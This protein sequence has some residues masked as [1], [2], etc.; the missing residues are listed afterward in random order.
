G[1]AS[2]RLAIDTA[3]LS[4][5][6]GS[7]PSALPRAACYD[8]LART[9]RQQPPGTLGAMARLYRY[10]RWDGTQAG[11]ELD[12]E[13]V[14]GE[15][16]DDLL[17]HGDL[18]A[19]LRRALQ[20]GMRAPDGRQLEGL[21]QLL[22]RIARRRRE[23]LERHEVSGLGEDIARRLDEVMDLE[24]QALDRGDVPHEEA[25]ARH[26]RLDE[27]PPDLAGRFRELSQYDFADNEARR[28]FEELTDELRQ[29]L[30]QS[31]FNRLAQGLADM[32]PG[33]RSAIKAIQ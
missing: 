32:S 30:L 29:Q 1:S 2:V 8:S 33:R 20:S 28:R 12:A 6:R 15:I 27:M 4:P 3:P 7:M 17:Y 14:L 16:A 23:E 19:A 18:N 26:Q 10:R 24:R 11:F 13:G 22:E 31:Q 21:R 5:S 25:Q 9:P